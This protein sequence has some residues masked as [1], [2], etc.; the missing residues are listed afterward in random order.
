MASPHQMSV[1]DV[2]LRHRR[3]IGIWPT[4][5]VCDAATAKDVQDVLVRNA[6]N[7]DLL[8]ALANVA[9]REEYATNMICGPFCEGSTHV[10]INAPAGRAGRTGRA[11]RAGRVVGTYVH[12]FAPLML[13]TGARTSSLQQRWIAELAARRADGQRACQK[14]CGGV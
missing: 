6:A 14:V 7:Y 1:P 5:G 13:A 9:T 4:A 3:S 11:G 12:V 10:Q 8:H 2:I